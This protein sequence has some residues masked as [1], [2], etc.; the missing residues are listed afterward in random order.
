LLLLLLYYLVVEIVAAEKVLNRVSPKEQR[1][2]LELFCI[3]IFPRVNC[4]SLF[5][6]EI[7]LILL[8]HIRGNQFLLKQCL[9]VVVFE[10]NV[11]FDLMRP[12]E[13]ESI[14]W[15]SLKAFVNK[16][17]CL[18]RPALRDLMTTYLYLLRENIV[19]NVFSG[20]PIVRPL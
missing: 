17:G 16:V 19:P 3:L 20:F 12:V 13:T 10:P 6:I 15:L 14:S 8:R 2:L 9:P 18:N 1:I 5:L 4:I 11:L 7:F